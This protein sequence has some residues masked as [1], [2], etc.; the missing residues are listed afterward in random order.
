MG[1]RKGLFE[2]ILFTIFSDDIDE[3]HCEFSKFADDTKIASRVRTPKAKDSGQIS[4]VG[5]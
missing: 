2:P 3:E 4:C 5:K 1:F